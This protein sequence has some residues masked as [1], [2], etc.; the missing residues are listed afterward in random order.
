ME[1]EFECNGARYVLS[2]AGIL[3]KWDDEAKVWRIASIPI[4]SPLWNVF[5]IC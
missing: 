3:W 1:N 4:K 5:P 2:E